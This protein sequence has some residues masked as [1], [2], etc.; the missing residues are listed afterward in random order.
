MTL[1]SEKI[2]ISHRCICGLIPNL[3]KK[4]WMVST[5]YVPMYIQV[6]FFFLK[7]IDVI[8]GQDHLLIT[9]PDCEVTV[10]EAEDGTKN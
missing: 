5:W 10:D 9:L 6:R 8:V 2:L 3:I 4:S 7:P 1:F